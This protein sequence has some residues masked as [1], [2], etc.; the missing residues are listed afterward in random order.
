MNGLTPTS[1]LELLKP[2][3]QKYIDLRALFIESAL[4]EAAHPPLKYQTPLG[5]SAL[6]H[7]LHQDERNARL[8]PDDAV[9][10]R[11]L[12]EF[13]EQTATVFGDVK[14]YRLLAVFTG[15]ILLRAN[16]ASTRASLGFTLLSV[17]TLHSGAF[18]ISKRHQSFQPPSFKIDCATQLADDI[19]LLENAITMLDFTNRQLE[20]DI[21]TPSP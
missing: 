10:F 19:P 2:V 5:R 6:H 20:Q 12:T 3:T 1:G 11:K 4:F 16:D 8:S 14:G 18:E 9:R 15:G 17:R 7:L 21:K 13:N